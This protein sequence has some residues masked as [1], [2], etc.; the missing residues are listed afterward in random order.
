MRSHV[1]SGQRGMALLL[2]LL[3]LLIASAIGLG[4][5]Y[6]S[7]TESL[8]SSNYKDSQLAF[9]A[10]RA[11][12]EEGRDRIRSNAG[13]P[14]TVAGVAVP[15]AWPG[16]PNSIVY[17]TNPSSAGDPVV[18]TAPGNAYFDDEFCH[19]RFSTLVYGTVPALNV[20]CSGAAQA[21]PGASAVTFTSIDPNTGTAA[22]LKYKWVRMTL[23]QNGTIP[24]ATVDNTQPGSSQVCWDS[25]G[26]QEVAISRFG[27]ASCTAAQNAGLNVTPVYVIT[28]MAITPSGSRRIGQ[29]EV[30]MFNMVPPPAALA[31]DGP[32]A[33]FNPA[34]SSNNYFSNGTDATTQPGYHWNGAGSCTPTGASIVPSVATGDATGQSSVT[35]DI[36]N[37]RY[38]NYTG[39]NV[40]NPTTGTNTP[41]VVN[42]GAGGTNALSGSW[43]SPYDLNQLVKSLA[44]VADV[45][46]SCGIG[47]PCNGSAP[48]GTDANPQITYVNGDFNFGSN[49]GAGVLIVTGTLNI[50]GQS[51]FDGLILVIGQGKIVE[52]GGGNGQFNGSIFLAN[53]NATTSPY[54]QLATLGSPLI[55]WNGGGTNGIQ[56]NSCWANIGNTMGYSVIASR[57]EMY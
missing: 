3:A 36:P 6:M 38:G 29:Y 10:M 34:P 56:Y 26:T 53:T 33:R 21:A 7:S 43:S 1:R 2:A 45:T 49:S 20:P 31:L 40:I 51:S 47:A 17:I 41:N 8:I 22:A 42:A 39:T 18:P 55:A 12:L 19:E 48:Y 54:G 28:S 37:N 50:T 16:S 52:N 24:N 4:L 25:M 14:L 30:G 44:A 27:Y 57:E 9:F 15:S 35:T 23:K 11:G 13:N 46:Y 32:G 5:M